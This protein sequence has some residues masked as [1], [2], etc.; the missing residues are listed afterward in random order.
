MKYEEPRIQILCLEWND[1]VTLS[2]EE[3]GSGPES[4]GPW[5]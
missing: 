4:E 5:G 2:G 3:G 1:V